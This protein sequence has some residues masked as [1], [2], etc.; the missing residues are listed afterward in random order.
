M[1]TRAI[2][3]SISL[4]RKLADAQAEYQRAS[5]ECQRLMCIAADIR[6]LDDTGNVDGHHALSQ[7]LKIHRHARLK[8]ET[9]LREFTEYILSGKAPPRSA[10]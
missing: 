9:A 10:S 4:K 6:G 5:A 8:Y 1:G 7:A 3:L 2:D